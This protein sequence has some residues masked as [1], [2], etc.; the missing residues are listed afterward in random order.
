MQEGNGTPVSTHQGRDP[1]TGDVL[2]IETAGGR[3]VRM[4]R[5]RDDSAELP[6]IGPGLIDLQ[7]NGFR[8]RDVNAPDG[9]AEM[10]VEIT[11]SLARAGTLVWVPTI[12][13]ASSERICHALRVIAE[14]RAAD[15]RIARAIPFAH[16]EG[17]FLSD[18]DGPR[19]VHDQTQIR[20]IDADE[21]VRWQACG[22]LGYVT[23]SPHWSDAPEQIS[24]IVDSGVAVAIGHTHA[25]P[26]QILAAVDAGASLSTHLGNGI[27]AELPRHPN[28][29]WS[30]LG[31]DRLT[32]G[33]IA[34]GHH[35]P[36]ETLTAMLRAKGQGRAFLVS[37]AVE[38]AG[39]EPG[40]YETAVGGT[41]EL[42]ADGRMSYLGTDLLA[43][44]AASLADCSRTSGAA[45]AE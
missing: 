19:G 21:V 39:S 35:L 37:D 31:D 16:V 5:Q 44:S 20:P 7:V 27:F 33:F 22:P 13:T 25:S 4:S 29:V 43:G 24:R 9:T 2:N 34:D 3:I 28:P 41:V 26:A 8:G 6:W 23:V 14:A 17:P 30:Q 15:P 10:I 32:C 42:T 36:A 18:L 12:V 38:S 1:Y 40:R 11:E 45:P